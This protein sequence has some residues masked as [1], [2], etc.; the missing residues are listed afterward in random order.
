MLPV[1]PDAA[2]HYLMD[3]ITLDRST[4]SVEKKGETS[5]LRT[6]SS[7]DAPKISAAIRVNALNIC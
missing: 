2:M 6:D 5:L 1:T 3:I 4:P 7:D